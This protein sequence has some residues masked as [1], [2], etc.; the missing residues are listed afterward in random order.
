MPWIW[1]EPAR[2]QVQLKH[3]LVNHVP[4]VKVFILCMTQKS[5]VEG[6]MIF[7]DASTFALEIKCDYVRKSLS[8]YIVPLT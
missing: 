8:I 6:G 3:L 1:I 2:F 7:N 4:S 5:H